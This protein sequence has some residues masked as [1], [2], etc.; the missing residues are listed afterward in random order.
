MN[1]AEEAQGKKQ[2]NEVEGIS[3]RTIQA[4][5]VSHERLAQGPSHKDLWCQWTSHTNTQSVP[6]LC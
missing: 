3:H 6:R 2:E 1:S 5:W 4:R